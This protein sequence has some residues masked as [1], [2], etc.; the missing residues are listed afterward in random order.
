MPLPSANDTDADLAAALAA[1][2]EHFAP[3]MEATMRDIRQL[4]AGR[5]PQQLIGRECLEHLILRERFNELASAQRDYAEAYVA[6]RQP[7][8][9]A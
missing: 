2:R 4:L 8:V 1:A 9:A 3:Q 6:R 7:P 5:D